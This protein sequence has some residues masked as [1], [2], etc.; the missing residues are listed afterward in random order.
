MGKRILFVGGGNMATSLIGGL[1]SRGHA[2]ADLVVA[3]PDAAQRTRLER[4][5]HVATA[6]DAASALGGVQT[7]VLAVKPQQMATVARGLAMALSGRRPLVISVAAGIRLQD[8][9]RWLGPDVPLVRTMPNR[10]ALMGAGITALYAAPGVDAAARATAEGILAACGP[11]VWVPD[12]AQMD[13]VTAV[14]GSGPAYFFLL[15]ECLEAAGIELGLDPGAA[16]QLAIETARG[17]GRMAAESAE[18]PAELR[19]QVTSKGGTTAAA[20]EVLEAADVR[21]IFARAVAAGAA[22]STALARE[23]GTA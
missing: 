20:L 4:D 22:R 1:L 8:L 23:F 10:P 11:T 13:V 6:A 9:A 14:S 5:Y 16:R 3:D 21:G 12:E 15:I 19:Q 2:A 17:A 18:S 7:V